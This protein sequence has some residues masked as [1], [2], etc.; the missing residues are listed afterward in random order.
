MGT[1]KRMLFVS[2][3]I[4]TILVINVKAAG[5]NNPSLNPNSVSL[6]HDGKQQ[7]TGQFTNSNSWCDVV[8]QYYTSE[9]GSWTSLGN[10]E[11]GQTKP[12][13]FQVSAPSVGSGTKTVSVKI[14]CQYGGG[15]C[16]YPQENWD[17]QITIAYGPSPEESQATQKQTTAN[18][19]IN[20]AKSAKLGLV[21]K[22][23]GVGAAA[24]GAAGGGF[25]YYRWRKKK[26][27]KKSEGK[28]H[29]EKKIKHD[30]DE[31]EH[32]EKKSKKIL[33]LFSKVKCPK[34]GHK[35]KKNQKFCPQCGKKV[36]D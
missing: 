27:G 28:D 33:S 21:K 11:T 20:N 17:G 16:S 31:K 7:I 4:F 35:I 36:G 6:Y 12:F 3:F 9:S 8:C 29:A 26:K 13:Q 32:K 23:A 25:L 22:V 14:N 15:L 24:A 5:I 19:E 30:K 18:S 2:I 34:C 1:L 10:A